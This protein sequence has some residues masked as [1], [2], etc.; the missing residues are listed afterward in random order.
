MRRYQLHHQK[1]NT[2]TKPV[3]RKVWKMAIVFNLS[4]VTI[5]IMYLE[6]VHIDICDT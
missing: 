5:N 3:E 4:V 6:A 1:N 2:K